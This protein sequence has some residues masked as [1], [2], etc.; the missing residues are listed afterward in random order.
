MTVAATIFN[1]LF[2]PCPEAAF[3]GAAVRHR[4]PPDVL[5]LVT[6]LFWSFNFTVG[7]FTNR[8]FRKALLIAAF[9]RVA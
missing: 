2:W 5:L 4:V 6:V 7:G 3:S 8:P 9:Q 1:S